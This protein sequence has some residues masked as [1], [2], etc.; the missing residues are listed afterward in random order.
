MRTLIYI[1]AL[2]F[3]GSAYGQSLSVFDVD[4]SGYPTINAKFY[5]YNNKWEQLINLQPLDFEVTEN[6]QLRYATLVTC[7]TLKPPDAL[8]SVLVIDASGSM[9]LDSVHNLNLAIEAAKVWIENLPLGKSECAIT[10]FDSRNY[11]MQDFTTD[12]NKLISALDNLKPKG[13][14]D[15]NQ[16]FI[17]PSA[18]C[19]LITMK[20]IH[21]R[22]VVFL[23]DGQP[24]NPP[25]T[26][27]IIDEANMQAVTIY[28]V[29][30]NTEA[31]DCLKEI[32]IQ[33][34]GKWY[35]KITTVEQIKQIY[36]Q[37]LHTAQSS[38]P[39]SIEW[40]SLLSCESE[41]KNV[42]IKL[43]INGA[44]SKTNYQIPNNSLPKLVF[45]PPSVKFLKAPPGIKK[46]TIITITAMNADFKITNITSLNP[47]FS[48]APASFNLLSGQSKTLTLSFI[49]VDSGY[50]ITKFTIDNDICPSKYYANGGFPG[51]KAGQI[52]LKLIHPNGGQVF[53]VGMDTLI[54]WEGVLP[55]EKVK[56]EFTTN[57]GLNWIK[58]SDTAKGFS[59]P[60]QVPKTPSNQC[61]A[62]VI[63]R[64]TDLSEDVNGEILVCNQIWKS[65]NLNVDQY[66]NGD[67]IPEV[68]DP[69]EWAAL[70]TGAWCYYDNNPAM[71]LK[72]GKLYNWYAINDPR[73]LASKGWHVPDDAEWQELIDCLGGDS[74]AGGKLKSTGTVEGT[75]GLWRRPNFEAT[76]ES[77]FSANP[78]GYRR[79]DG[80]FN[81][82]GFWGYWW[83]SKDYDI[84][85]AWSIVLIN[86]ET[87]IRKFGNLKKNGFSV[88]IVRD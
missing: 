23:S 5:A 17:E 71:G 79:F 57:N 27:S 40:K 13:G 24:D 35:D 36:F 3:S 51:K 67:S 7:P 63:S 49:P 38:V 22:V 85:G 55:D 11:L 87:N 78:G 34:G 72:Y 64:T 75:T 69:F 15:Y 10:S 58:I 47:S 73:G 59:Y 60:W 6:G 65:N 18:G 21:K 43:L 76:N 19:L 33:T 52:T 9:G 12:R 56:L 16:A 39:C 44:T 41:L 88:R 86:K 54:S 31:P 32:S 45:N 37:I 1:L 29:T 26:S 66:Q 70:K 46:D 50:T 68:R 4:P 14:T 61:I 77:D 80:S 48:I 25:R 42:E 2:M 8:S 82:F 81:N 83:T 30:L 74:I 20:G 84:S 62:R 28:T 53:V